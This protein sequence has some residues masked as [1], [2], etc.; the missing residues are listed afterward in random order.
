[1]AQTR[2]A[3]LPTTSEINPQ[4]FTI[5]ERPGIGQ[6][7]YK[8][9]VGDLQ[10]AITVHATVEQEE[11][12]TT[13]TVTDING[14]TQEKI[15]TPTAKI[16]DNGNN[17]A[18][19]T[20]TDTHGTTTD[21]IV[22]RVLLDPFPIEGSPNMLTSGSIYQVR[23]L[24]EE[25][26]EAAEQRISVTESREDA[27][28]A[29]MDS[30]DARM[31]RIEARI[32]RLEE[33]IYAVEETA[34]KAIVIEDG[35]HLERPFKVNGVVYS[36]LKD[37]MLAAA[38]EGTVVKLLSDASNKGI[39]IPSGTEVKVNLNGKTLNMTGPGEGSPGTKTLG[40]QL[41]KDSTITFSNGTIIFDDTRLKMG[42]QNYCNLTLDNVNISGGPTITYVVSN[43]FG[44][45]VFKNGTV[46]TASEGRVAFDA[47]FG[48]A[49][50]YYDGVRIT[51]PESSVQINGIVEYGKKTG[52]P[53]D[54]FAQNA[55][56]TIPISM[57][58]DL[59]I[60]TKPC[61]WKTN[62]D[63]TKTLYY[64]DTTRIDVPVDTE[65]GDDVETQTDQDLL[66]PQRRRQ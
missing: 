17:T 48:M 21:T 64:L 12:V 19:I 20:I 47:W 5:I 6:G 15:V 54:L 3:D 33:R 2:I 50:V 4:S 34:E 35:N 56:L 44:N 1:M 61:A 60:L 55:S 32:D 62:G 43:N 53:G 8:A 36:D 14:T 40:M 26:I 51:I 58:L 38:E 52:A 31:D 18:T 7:T 37:A 13:I 30:M 23:T 63:G 16:T 22:S 10:D 28:D 57:E 42:I 66:G 11:D 27:A 29:R 49:P 9:T 46:I 39:S 41:L 25:R 24:L 65:S 59:H 45:V